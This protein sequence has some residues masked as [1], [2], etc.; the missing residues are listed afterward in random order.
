MAG[1]PVLTGRALPAGAAG[2]VT[3]SN[4]ASV[5]CTKQDHCVAVE[6]DGRVVSTV[7]GGRTWQNFGTKFSAPVK[8]DLTSRQIAC[9]TGSFCVLTESAGRNR[10]Y[11]TVNG[12]RTW[13]ARNLDAP[14]QGA[15]CFPRNGCII[16]I[17]SSFLQVKARGTGH[18]LTRS[19]ISWSQ[20]TRSVSCPTARLCTAA[21]DL[22]HGPF[23]GATFS[24]STDGGRTWRLVYRDRS[25]GNVACASRTRCV[26][27]G[28]K[29]T[30]AYSADGARTFT[31]LA[32][33]TG[34][35]SVGPVTC[36]APGRCLAEVI[37]DGVHR[38]ATVTFPRRGK[39][40]VTLA[41]GVVPFAHRESG[42]LYIH[43]KSA[44]L[45]VV[46]RTER[47]TDTDSTTGKEVPLLAQNV[48]VR[49]LGAWSTDG[50]T[51]W[52]TVD[53]RNEGIF[54][55]PDSL[56]ATF[57]TLNEPSSGSSESFPV[58][59]PRV[60]SNWRKYDSRGVHRDVPTVDGTCALSAAT[61]ET[62]MKADGWTQTVASKFLSRSYDMTSN[63]T[64]M[65]MDE[66]DALNST[67]PTATK[68]FQSEWTKG[69]VYAVLAGFHS[70]PGGASPVC[71]VWAFYSFGEPDR[72]VGPPKAE[73][74]PGFPDECPIRIT[75]T[76]QTLSLDDWTQAAL[77]GLPTGSVHTWLFSY[78]TTLTG[79]GKRKAMYSAIMAA[80]KGQK[81]YFD[82]L[83][84]TV[85]SGQDFGD[86][87]GKYG[88]WSFKVSV[89]QWT[90]IQVR[91]W[92]M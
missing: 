45:C 43:C 5:D 79:L 83:K 69:R 37:A 53:P 24:R 28:R 21:G 64:A 89:S 81:I 7:D 51:T 78:D 47:F 85:E 35:T 39:P 65:T 56:P 55:L 34:V 66:I 91:F 90:T 17:K 80:L 71:T 18:S 20:T 40:T 29:Q 2:A 49:R 72:S 1:I 58:T 88:N 82:M 4:L 23:S 12:G 77:W 9:A 13:T 26:G 19:Y 70:P 42:D 8:S 14:L 36:G 61:A 15:W 73:V 33:P 10:L 38:V 87:N 92:T 57:G 84:P 11:V 30:F 75:G 50:G 3:V 67:L 54:E 31:G 74:D 32:H 25:V 22:G 59:R 46:P 62:A 86:I 44:L 68:G 6:S 76:T 60:N 27:T 52:R 63:G 16:K 41:E 48:S